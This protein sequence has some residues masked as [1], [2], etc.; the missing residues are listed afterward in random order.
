[1]DN[2]KFLLLILT[3]GLPLAIVPIQ[4]NHIEKLLTPPEHSQQYLIETVPDPAKQILGAAYDRCL[5]V[6]SEEYQGNDQATYHCAFITGYTP[7]SN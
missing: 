3:L 2:Y 6:F 4:L 1:M 5:R 7:A